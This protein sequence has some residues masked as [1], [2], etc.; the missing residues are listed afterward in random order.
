MFDKNNY[1]HELWKNMLDKN[2]DDEIQLT[3]LLQGVEHLSTKS[4]EWCLDRQTI[5]HFSELDGADD[6]VFPDI[7]ITP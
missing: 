5:D 6:N 1:G 3:T 7:K 4:S 2:I